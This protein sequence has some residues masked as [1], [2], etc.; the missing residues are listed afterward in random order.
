MFTIYNATLVAVMQVGVIVAGVLASGLWHKFATSSGMAMPTLVGLLYNF[1]M[2]GFFIPLA[3]LAFAMLVRRS[4][5]ISDE[6]KGLTF[7]FGV[8]VLVSLTIF[9]IYAD[10]SPC[11]RIM[12]GLSGG[13]DA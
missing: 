12:W 6:L 11:F 5:R 3:W 1:G 9:M 2:A 10:V 13:D 7:W 4:R 8:A